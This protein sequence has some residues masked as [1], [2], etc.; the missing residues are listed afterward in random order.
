MILLL[1][2]LLIIGIIMFLKPDIIWMITESWKSD[3][4]YGPSNSYKISTKICGVMMFL[5]GLV[6]LIVYVFLI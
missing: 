6:S 3:N 1:I 4:A 5:V 2:L